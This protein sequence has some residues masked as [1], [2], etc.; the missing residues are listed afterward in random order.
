MKRQDPSQP[1]RSFFMSPVGWFFISTDQVSSLGPVMSSRANWAG[2]VTDPAEMEV[3][4]ATG[5]SPRQATTWT[6]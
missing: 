2:S 4:D 3:T 1:G 5:R 6:R